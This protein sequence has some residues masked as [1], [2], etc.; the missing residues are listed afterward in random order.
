MPRAVASAM[1]GE[2]EPAHVVTMEGA[3]AT[4]MP[5]WNGAGLHYVC[6]MRYS[7]SVFSL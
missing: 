4:R 3:H 1:P 6:H 5:S 2:D 7:S